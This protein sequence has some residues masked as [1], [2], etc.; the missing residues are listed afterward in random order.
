MRANLLL[1]FAAAFFSCSVAAQHDDDGDESLTQW[2]VRWRA[3]SLVS[4]VDT[5]AIAIPALPWQ[6]A[7]NFSTS[8]TRHFVHVPNILQQ[9]SGTLNF[10]SD[11]LTRTGFGLYYR[12]IGLGYSYNFSKNSELDFFIS[13]YGDAIGCDLKFEK[14]KNILSSVSLDSRANLVQQDWLPFNIN[15]LADNKAEFASLSFNFYYVFNHHKFSY[16]SA[17][18]QSSQQLVSAGSFIAGCSYYG[19]FLNLDESN[20]ASVFFADKMKVNTHQ[21]AIG[22]GY[23]YNYV[24]DNR[25]LLLHASFM[26]MMMFSVYANVYMTPLSYLLG[27]AWTDQMQ[28]FYIDRKT[29][30][31]NYSFSLSPSLMSVFRL[32]G[33]W[34]ITPSWI[35]GATLLVCAYSSPNLL[36]VTSTTVDY[37]ARAYLGFCF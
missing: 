20:V 4:S 33:Y 26:P 35:L 30:M 29:D 18:G 22:A 7:L 28:A 11:F 9:G 16:G 27:S 24:T 34:N 12:G 3:E 25:R 17:L 23:G 31:V 14:R 19:S 8:R 2:F 6:V 36:A 37:I 32:A 15:S 5:A 21:L 10:S 13:S 1:F